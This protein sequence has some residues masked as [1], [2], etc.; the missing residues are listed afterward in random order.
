M[1]CLVISMKCLLPLILL[2]VVAFGIYWY[3][4]EASDEE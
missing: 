3:M 4:E 1:K 2:G